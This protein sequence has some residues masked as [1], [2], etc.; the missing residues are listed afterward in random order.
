[1]ASLVLKNLPER[2]HS[3]LKKQAERNRRSMAQEAITVLD[4]SLLEV[5]PIVPPKK[6]IKPLKPITGQ[7]ILDAIREGRR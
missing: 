3:R 2:I 1:M 6:L 4:R 7:M 5:P